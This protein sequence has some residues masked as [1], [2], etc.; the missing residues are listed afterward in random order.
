MAEYL[1]DEITEYVFNERRLTPTR[2]WAEAIAISLVSL[3]SHP[4]KVLT[5][6]G[7]IRLN[8]WYIF[9]GPSSLASK[10]FHWISSI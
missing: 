7:F 3:F 1:I 2:D 10:K 6:K 9:I 8:L 4:A 5:K